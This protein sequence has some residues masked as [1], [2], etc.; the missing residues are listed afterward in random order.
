MAGRVA[1]LAA[2]VGRGASSGPPASTPGPGASAGAPLWG[3]HP[4]T[5]P[6]H[7]PG[8]PRVLVT[9]SLLLWQERQGRSMAQWPLSRNELRAVYF[10]V[11]PPESL[12]GPPSS[13]LFLRTRFCVTTDLQPGS[14]GNMGC[15]RVP[16]TPTRPLCPLPLQPGNHPG[17]SSRS[18]L[19]GK[20]WGR[21]GVPCT[22][23]YLSH[24]HSP[25]CL[26]TSA[27]FIPGGHPGG[28]AR[29]PAGGWT[30]R[31][32]KTR[33]PGAEWGQPGRKS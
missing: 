6:Q 2:S 24:P 27:I 10:R 21:E 25:L 12:E 28:G 5:D 22:P 8:S 33:C 31:A 3:L 23:A 20:C 29:G 18:W 30:S 16:G 1:W 11:P 4:C 14:P 9:P 13:S 7:H 32:E 15:R 17:P 26:G 19:R